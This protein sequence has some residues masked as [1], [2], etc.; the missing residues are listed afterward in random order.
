MMWHGH[1]GN[2][3]HV[4]IPNCYVKGICDEFPKTEEL[5]DILYTGFK[6]V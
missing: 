5:G 1:F 6:S 2:I 4:Q 3:I